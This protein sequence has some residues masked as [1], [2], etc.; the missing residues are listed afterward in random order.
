MMTVYA[1]VPAQMYLISFLG[2][3]GKLSQQLLP[4]YFQ[5]SKGVRGAQYDSYFCF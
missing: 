4:W 2:C 3:A 5:H 1:V